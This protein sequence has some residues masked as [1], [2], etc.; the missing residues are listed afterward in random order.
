[1]N[2]LKPNSDLPTNRA[3]DQDAGADVAWEIL[4]YIQRHPDCADSVEGV[5]Q[6]WLL[7]ERYKLGLEQVQRA[8]DELCAKGYLDKRIVADGTAIYSAT[9]PGNSKQYQ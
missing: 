6:W 1:M 4:R 5:V 8:L 2:K 3:S 9:K 7:R